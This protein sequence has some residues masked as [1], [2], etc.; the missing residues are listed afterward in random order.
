[1]NKIK[2]MLLILSVVIRFN[3]NAQK[4]TP[5]YLQ[6]P[7]DFIEKN[8]TI[9]DPSGWFI[10]NK[11]TKV[12][13]D[14]FLI[15]FKEYF[16]MGRDDKFTLLSSK[17]DDF[18]F[19]NDENRLT[20]D[21]YIQTYKGLEVEF[22]EFF[23]HSQ[24]NNIKFINCKLVEH[25]NKDV[26]PSI[27]EE[28]ALAN[29]INTLGLNNTYSWQIDE[30]ERELKDQLNDPYATYF[31]TGKLLLAKN[32]VGPNYDPSE[33]T[34]AWKFNIY[35]VE[36]E[37]HVDIYI[38][39]KTGDLLKTQ[40]KTCENG[41][42]DLLYYGN[43]PIDTKWRGF[44]NYN[45]ALN[46]EDNSRNI[47]TKY[48]GNIVTGFNGWSNVTDG[49]D[50]WGWGDRM[51]TTPHWCAIQSWDYFKNNYNRNGCKGN[52]RNINVW[53]NWNDANAQYVSVPGADVIKVGT[54]IGNYLATSDII[55]HEF[56]HGVTEFTAGL[57]YSYES[58]ALNESFS[59]IFGFMVER[60]TQGGTIN[61]WD[62][63]EDALLLR[64]MNNPSNSPAG[65]QPSI[66]LGANWFT[67]SGDNGGVHTNS[68]VQNYW[69]YL[70]SQGS[71]GAPDGTFN[72]RTVNGI[73]VV[74]A[75]NIS[76]Y[77]LTNILGCNSN[78]VDAAN[79]AYMA[80]YTIYGNCSMEW[81]QTV[82]AWAA[83]GIGNPFVHL[84]ISGP[85]TIYYYYNGS[86]SGSMPKIFTA[87]GSINA[88]G[89]NWV[90][91]GPWQYAISGVLNENFSI[92]NFQGNFTSG[93]INLM[94]QCESII[95][96]INFKCIDC[97][98]VY[99]G[100]VGDLDL[101]ISPN[102]TKDLIHIKANFIDQKSDKPIMITI[103]DING[104]YMF[105]QYY[106]HS[107]PDQI[108]VSHF[109]SGG[110]TVIVHQGN[111]IQQSK[112]SKI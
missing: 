62:L 59:D 44:P 105:Q 75:A 36:P 63:G 99:N 48:Q 88:S 13:A 26:N 100:H 108:N 56:T 34:L 19:S 49:D 8:C 38:D 101:I 66:Y 52:G 96:P 2:L 91:I 84:S 74:K 23:I 98:I 42:A 18:P 60:F 82:N 35:S 67:G 41:T 37:L 14:N 16:G 65:A 109:E 43:Q 85:S 17:T 70:L 3:S 29:A 86:P 107:L 97:P 95:K 30:L 40:S 58:G 81:E 22:A 76:Y 9:L 87:H 93:T 24:D 12:P 7:N 92:T 71:T 110:Y 68:G 83:V 1:M 64:R 102:P 15:N 103:I 53:A 73:G 72:G 20:H 39:A 77:N 5:N 51:A 4:Y 31:P 46:A 45:F 33:F 28:Q 89:Y 61:D 94:G 32:S 50:T 106:Y 90:Y 69:F 112:F 104:N 54:I 79:G 47:I 111:N 55:G 25:L 80:A 27:T 57:V 6:Q 10:F 11:N 21:R 78:Y